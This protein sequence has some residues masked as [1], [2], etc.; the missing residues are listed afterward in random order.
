MK[1][2]YYVGD[3][4]YVMPDW[5]IVCDITID[6]PDV[7]SGVFALPDG[8]RFAMYSTAEGDGSYED[9]HGNQYGVDSGSLGIVD[10]ENVNPSLT[11]EDLN[12]Y[13]HV[14][15]L[16]FDPFDD[17]YSDEGIIHLGIAS[18]NTNW[19]DNEDDDDHDYSPD[20]YEDDEE[21]S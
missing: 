20:H 3:L 21:D 2:Q 4:C 5:D 17:T 10:I 15:E 16:D 14:F 11:M 9:Q 12:E 18:I 6:G 19:Y 8:T 13:G 1:K 7:K